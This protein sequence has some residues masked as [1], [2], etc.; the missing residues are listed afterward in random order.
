MKK[1]LQFVRRAQINFP[2]VDF[3]GK[4]PLRQPPEL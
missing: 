3:T 1:A 2:K 4:N